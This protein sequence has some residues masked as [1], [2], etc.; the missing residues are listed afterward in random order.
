MDTSPR[1]NRASSNFEVTSSKKPY[2]FKMS[3]H[4]RSSANFQVTSLYLGYFC[5]NLARYDRDN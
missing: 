2:F 3:A 1:D 5:E 4:D